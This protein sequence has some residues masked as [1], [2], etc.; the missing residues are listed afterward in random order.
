MKRIF[1]LLLIL[2]LLLAGCGAAD[3]GVTYPDPEPRQPWAL[4]PEELPDTADSPSFSAAYRFA[5]QAPA[6]AVKL[7]LFRLE[8]GLWEDVAGGSWM[9]LPQECSGGSLALS[10]DALWDSC[11]IQ[12]PEA[13]KSLDLT[14]QLDTDGRLSQLNTAVT[15]LN[16]RTEAQWGELIPL[17]LQAASPQDRVYPPDPELFHSPELA[18]TQGYQ[19]VYLLAMSL[20]PASEP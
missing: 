13:T 2:S 10:F 15:F 11:R 9:A 12:N 3:P 4:F 5:S 14:A 16:I 20:Q 17:V 7:I 18:E 8:N 6:G 19:E 1:A